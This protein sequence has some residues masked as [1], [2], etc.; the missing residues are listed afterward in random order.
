M[1]IQSHH[2][3]PLQPK[4]LDSVVFAGILDTL[5]IHALTKILNSFYF[6][7]HFYQVE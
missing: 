2:L 1:R 3:L 4:K 5:L 7:L 6:M